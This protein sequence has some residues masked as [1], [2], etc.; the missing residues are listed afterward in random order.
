MNHILLKGLFLSLLTCT[1]IGLNAEFRIVNNTNSTILIKY[2]KPK[3]EAAIIK[4]KPNAYLPDPNFDGPID[5]SVA[6]DA[7]SP[8]W[9]GINVN[10]I[11]KLIRRSQNDIALWMVRPT[12]FGYEV[13]L[14]WDR[15]DKSL[16]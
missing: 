15:F 5:L 11:F 9:V 4:I 3:E 8:R 12:T 14:E 16:D 10:E 7:K 2:A 1:V 13:K 6:K